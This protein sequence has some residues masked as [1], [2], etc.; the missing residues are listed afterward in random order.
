[1]VKT[2]QMF[3]TREP[4]QYALHHQHVHNEANRAVTQLYAG[5]DRYNFSEVLVRSLRD[6]GLGSWHPNSKNLFNMPFLNCILQVSWASA[7]RWNLCSTV[8]NDI[9]R[10]C[11][12]TVLHKSCCQYLQPNLRDMMR[13]YL[14]DGINLLRCLGESGKMLGWG[15]NR[16]GEP[17]KL[18]HGCKAEWMARVTMLR[19]GHAWCTAPLGVPQGTLRYRFGIT[20]ERKWTLVMQPPSANVFSNAM[21][22]RTIDDFVIR[23]CH[24]ISPLV[25]RKF[26]HC[27]CR[28]STIMATCPVALLYMIALK[29]SIVLTDY[30]KKIQATHEGTVY[31]SIN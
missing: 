5:R 11:A 24:N 6:R 19:V 21:R 20:L 28:D 30:T 7:R 1:M 18:Y 15:R 12:H 14:V 3:V 29:Q 4:K 27:L 23:R 9:N 22:Y 8:M 13:N 2:L 16:I 25:L 31:S 10:L 26:W 17:T